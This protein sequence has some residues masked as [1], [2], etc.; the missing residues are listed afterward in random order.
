[1]VTSWPRHWDKTAYKTSFTIG[2]LHGRVMN[3]NYIVD[4]TPSVF[5]K[6]DRLGLVEKC[7]IGEVFNKNVIGEKVW[8]EFR[9]EKAIDCPSSYASYRDGWYVDETA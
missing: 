2:M 6:V 7:W 9:L 8:F 3:P 5:I 4:H 1:L